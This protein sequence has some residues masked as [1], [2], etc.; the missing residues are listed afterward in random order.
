MQMVEIVHHILEEILKPGDRAVDG[1]AGNGWDTL[2]LC[3]LVGETGRVYGFDVQE[4]AVLKTEERLK[5]AGCLKQ[6]EL[7][8]CSHSEIDTKVHEKIKAFTLNLGYLPGGDKQVVTKK[9][10]TI[11]AL[12]KLS[13]M[14]M[15]GGVGTILIYYGHEGGIEEKEGVEK[16]MAALPS[17][18]GQVNRMETVNRKNCPP[19][20][21]IL[22]K[23]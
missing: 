23:K 8:C 13:E 12:E 17:D 19:I 16:F 5:A 18:W 20:L 2:K 22:E 1:T 14:L 3:Q 6:A 15:P 11:K 7:F 10:S 9:D 21:Y 4:S